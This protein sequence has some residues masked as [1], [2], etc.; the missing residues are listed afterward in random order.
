MSQADRSRSRSRKLRVR[1]LLLLVV[2]IPTVGM[3]TMA[4]STASG[5]LSK[6][7][8]LQQVQEKADTLAVI[9]DARLAIADEETQ[10]SVVSIAADLGTDVSTLSNLYGIDYRARMARARAAVDADPVIASLPE[11]DAARRR[12]R[13]LRTSI[14]AGTATFDQTETVFTGLTSTLDADWRAR[15]A[16]LQTTLAAGELPG[17]LNVRADDLR[18]TFDALSWGGLRANQA[19]Q[20]L[21]S[22]PN[23]K[24]LARMLDA[25][26]RYNSAT[27]SFRGRLGPRSASAWKR[28]EVDPASQR[29]EATLSA[30]A[31]AALAGVASPLATDPAAFG[32]AF[33]D[34]TPWARGLTAVVRATANDLRAN[35]AQEERAATDDLR[36]QLAMATA[37]TV[38]AVAGALVLA[39]SVNRPIRRL[40]AAAHEIHDGHFDLDPIETNGPREL[41]DTAAAFNEM[42]N[43]LAAV[44]AHA[45]ALADDT[46]APVLSD[47]LPGPTGRA[48]QVAMN[49]LR[50]SMHG[51][52]QHRRE[53]EQAATHDGLTGL[54]NRTAALAMIDRDLAQASRAGGQVMALFVDL[55]G[56]K[57]INDEHGHAAGDDALRLTADAL[58]ATTRS[59]DVVARLGGDEFL[60]ASI[61]GDR[62]EVQLL[63]ERIR[64]AVAAQ[65]LFGRNG[66]IPLHCSIGMALSDRAVGT[67]DALIHRADSALYLAKG[68]GRDQVAWADRVD[69]R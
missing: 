68:R 46:D 50:A 12:L 44:E 27:E 47:E 36:N 33:V 29:F 2:L 8:A 32:Q 7:H 48:L 24:A 69:M 25:T 17:S 35:A 6:R 64:E 10:S 55:D 63:A 43:T 26:S 59:G 54:L 62:V 22:E 15:L 23:P 39:R 1:S 53:L 18:S 16:E 49:R 40:E 21:R 45:V 11:L 3:V 9:I 60:V 31:Q 67:V 20:L 61:V 52:E 38:F 30:V 13:E 5:A 42:A 57:S 65:Q 58:R 4:A 41:A 56:L 37:L 51:A 14:D 28:Q 34:G 66:P 19:V